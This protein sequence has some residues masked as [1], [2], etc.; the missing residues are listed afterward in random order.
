MKLARVLLLLAAFQLE[1]RVRASS[2]TES[3]WQ[4]EG[5]AKTN[6]ECHVQAGTVAL[7]LKIEGGLSFGATLRNNHAMAACRRAVA[8][9]RHRFTFDHHAPALVDFFRTVIAQ[10]GRGPQASTPARWAERV[11]QRS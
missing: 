7:R 3:L 11:E 1:V 5:C 9:Q 6:A 8:S 10:A 2:A 4:P